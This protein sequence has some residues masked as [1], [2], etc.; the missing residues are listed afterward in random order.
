MQS[1]SCNLRFFIFVFRLTT[2]C[3]NSIVS[4]FMSLFSH[5]NGPSQEKA[6]IT[7][8]NA[9]KPNQVQSVVESQNSAPVE[10]AVDV[11]S[12][13][14]RHSQLNPLKTTYHNIWPRENVDWLFAKAGKETK[15]ADTHTSF[16][17]ATVLAWPTNAW[18]FKVAL[19]Y[20]NGNYVESWE[21][22]AT[23]SPVCNL[24]IFWRFYGLKD[25]KIYG[26]F[27]K[28]GKRPNR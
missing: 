21:F 25:V 4:P 23:S 18:T 11:L 28:S 6:F 15:P 10:W 22:M 9:T 24:P 8:N 27:W 5:F 17:C 13:T 1:F 12:Y 26:S 7:F 3:C 20:L 2:E 14:H 19:W 16:R